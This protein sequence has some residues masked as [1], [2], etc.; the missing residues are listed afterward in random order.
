M[1]VAM[2]FGDME[3]LLDN[4]VFRSGDLFLDRCPLSK[5]V[6]IGGIVGT[7]PGIRVSKGD[8]FSNIGRVAIS[9]EATTNILSKLRMISTT[10]M[11]FKRN[12]DP[13]H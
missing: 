11:V 8:T 2:P 3:I 6:F 7:N 4:M 9:S 5:H 13:S 12:F 10:T 1:T